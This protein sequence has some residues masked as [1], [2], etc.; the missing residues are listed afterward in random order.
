MN[1]YLVSWWQR[2]LSCLLVLVISLTAYSGALAQVQQG[3]GMTEEQTS[4]DVTAAS[5]W[6]EPRGL[7]VVELVGLVS[8]Q[9]LRGTILSFGDDLG[10]VVYESGSRTGNTV[11]VTTTIYPRLLYPSPG[12][13]MTY[14]GCLGQEPH[15]DHMGSVVPA[16][17][18][19]VY[20]PTGTE[21]TKSIRHMFG[22]HMDNLQPSGGSGEPFRYPME[23]Y[24]PGLDHPLPLA[25]DGLHIPSNSG[26][27]IAILG[28]D[29]PRLTGKFTLQVEPSVKASVVATQQAAFTSYIGPGNVGIFSP[30][31]QQLLGAFGARSP[32]IH[33]NIPNGANFF[34]LKFPPMPGDAYTDV[35]TNPPYLNAARLSAGTYRL[36]QPIHEL[37]TD[38]VFSA[39]F[40]L[41]RAWQ[42]ADQAPGSSFL[43]VM[44]SPSE[45]ETPEYVLP[46]G[47]S[48]NSCF[49]AGNCSSAVLQQIYDQQ[50][51]LEV[52]YLSIAKPTTGGQ[53]VSLRM[54]GP[55]W[56]SSAAGAALTMSD[57]A[58][59]LT[60]TEDPLQRTL[61]GP[62]DH[63]VF[64]PLVS[65]GIREEI[66]PVACP[67]GWFDVTGRMLGFSP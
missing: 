28:A 29:Y 2:L 26:C 52:V 11:V 41:R 51:M 8:E 5:S 30:L 47:I 67:C 31:M 55:A 20:T 4:S 39:A 36:W 63:R 61:A 17:V 54:A 6:L 38:L 48:Y 33:L 40:P 7:A 13:P 19:R 49:T 25:A 22:I 46:A 50:M 24:G 44:A 42:D 66:P 35:G 10:I 56:S 23:G 53:W 27:R 16:S 45:L 34:L 12:T 43:P 14:F 3:T 64:L 59:Q 21:V 62:L 65:T 60:S 9:L 1:K 37:S 57:P 32:R 58:Q 15:F 18:M